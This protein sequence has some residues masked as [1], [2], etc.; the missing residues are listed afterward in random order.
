MPREAAGPLETPNAPKISKYV[1]KVP[2]FDL[3][4]GFLENQFLTYF[5]PTLTFSGFG[6]P[7]LHNPSPPQVLKGQ[8]LSLNIPFNWRCVSIFVW[9]QTC[10]C[11]RWGRS[12]AKRA[13]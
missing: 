11:L 1:M 5:A 2:I 7:P 13:V 3:L 4:S 8:V 12:K 10:F 6:G 9:A